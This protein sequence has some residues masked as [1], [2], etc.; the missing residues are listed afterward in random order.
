MTHPAAG[1]IT[2]LMDRYRAAWK[3][4]DPAALKRCWDGARAPLYLA[5]EVEETLSDWAEI[6]RYWAANEGLHADVELSFS[7]PVFT[8]L[9]DN[10]V[11]GAWRMEWTIQFTD[12]PAMSGWNRVVAVYRAAPD[13]WRLAAWIEAPLAA[14]TYVRKLYEERAGG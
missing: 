9:A 13:S 2:A 7:E 11:M 14:V 3:T 1:A 8:D 4:N 6:E 12:K 5:E 10:L